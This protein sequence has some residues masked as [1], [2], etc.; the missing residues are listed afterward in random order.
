MKV[1]VFSDYI[2]PFCYIGIETLHR[3]Q[4]EVP[5][6]TLEWQGFQIHPEYPAT[7]IPMAQRADQVGKE[8]YAA[9]WQK[10]ETLAQEID[11][12]MQPPPLLTNSLLALEA[13]EYA[14]DQGKREVFS[15]IIYQAYFQ[16]EQNIGDIDV[17]LSLAERAELDTSA[18]Q[19][20][21]Q[22]RTY[23]PRLQAAQEEART[24]GISGVPTF[25]IGPAQIVGAQSQ[26]VLASML[27][28]AAERGLG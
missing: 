12:A 17:L 1:T 16:D 11:L 21:L 20:H 8:R 3:V 26:E 4:P 13:T 6:F 25:V 10:I 14:K 5:D 9:L 15:A 19:T 28:R 24:K 7:G 23:A 2:C 18:L 22:E 27:T